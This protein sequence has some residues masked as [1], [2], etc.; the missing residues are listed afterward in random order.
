MII[1]NILSTN[2]IS[3]KA[4]LYFPSHGINEP[5]DD[6]TRCGRRGKYRSSIVPLFG[7]RWGRARISQSTRKTKFSATNLLPAKKTGDHSRVAWRERAVREKNPH[8]TTL[9]MFSRCLAGC[10]IAKLDATL[11]VLSRNFLSGYRCPNSWFR[12]NGWTEQLV[13]VTITVPIYRSG[14]MVKTAI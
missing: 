9:M 12:L 1:D 14:S 10:R 4:T 3:E 7:G 5:A 6:R 11:C 13:L 8:K 2:T